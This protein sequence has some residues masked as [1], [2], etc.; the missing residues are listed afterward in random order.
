MQR[1][2][3]IIPRSRGS[4]VKAGRNRCGARRQHKRASAATASSGATGMSAGTS[5]PHSE[6]RGS[7][8]R[9]FSVPTRFGARGTPSGEVLRACTRMLDRETGRVMHVHCQTLYTAQ[10]MQRFLISAYQTSKLPPTSTTLLGLV[11]ACAMYV[12]SA[13]G[14]CCG[15]LSSQSQVLQCSR[16]LC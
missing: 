8:A 3:Y 13:R 5:S 1:Q 2:G 12:H 7:Q 9:P 14:S 11:G 16:M 4:W 15:E 10:Q 6:G